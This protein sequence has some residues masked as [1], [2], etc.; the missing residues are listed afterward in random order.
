MKIFLLIVL[1]FL[2]FG[3]VY[4]QNIFSGGDTVLT[5][6]ILVEANRIRTTVLLSPNKVQI[7]DEQKLN[8]VNGS[9]L[10]DA[11]KYSDAVFIR[12]YGFNSGLKT[13]S[14]NAT[15]TEHTLLL[16]NGVRLNSRQ[17]NQFD[18]GLLQTENIERIEISKG[19]SSA[20]Y[21]SEPIGGV[22]NIITK[23]VAYDKPFGVDM[24]LNFGSY[25]KRKIFLRGYK[26]F[27]LDSRNLSFALSYSGESAKNNYDYYYFNGLN[28]ILKDRDNSEYSGQ[29]F[30]FSSEFSGEFTRIKLNLFLNKWNRNIPGIE[31]GAEVTSA[32]QTDE[33]VLSTVSLHHQLKSK[34]SFIAKTTYRHSLMKYSDASTINLLYPINSYYKQSL[35]SVSTEIDFSLSVTNEIITGY[36][37]SFSNLNSNET[38]YGRLFNTAV[39]FTGKSELHIMRIGSFIFYPSA[40]IDYY[41]HVNKYVVTGKIGFNYKPFNKRDF[42]LKSSCGN[43]YRVPSFN[44]LYWKNLGNKELEPERSINYDGGLFYK[45][46]L[47]ADNQIEFSYF[48]NLIYNRIIWQPDATG[49]WR[50][51]NI[52]KVRTYGVDLSMNS[53]FTFSNSFN[54]NLGFNYNIGKS[55]KLNE[56]YP[57][58]PTFNKQLIYT[59]QEFAKSFFSVNYNFQQLVI[60]KLSLNIFYSFVGKRYTNPD[61]TRFAK[62]YELI[63]ANVNFIL[64]LLKTDFNIK[65]EVNNL[66]NENYQVIQGYPMPLRNY[67]IGL[68]YNYE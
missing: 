34:I 5:R 22:I 52:G 50:P 3:N 11:L 45:F 39:F 61:N 21:G 44:E 56:D 49:I 37:F 9:R 7:L 30:D 59:P 27:T 15:Q 55:L 10:S 62:Y 64:K 23:Q 54:V 19:G 26:N 57:G 2:F 8:S 13:I 4:S 6:E 35:F 58:D 38:E 67:S 40:R 46:K 65:F 12:D 32:K 47:L 41:S 25:N 16:L 48:N 42:T 66:L 60:K 1:S 68:G 28:N 53:E 17:N 18:F 31:T 36:D 29:S 24:H 20:L 14:L 43:N 51:V 63:D 33:D